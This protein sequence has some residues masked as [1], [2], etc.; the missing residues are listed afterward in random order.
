M[1][2]CEELDWSSELV[3]SDVNTLSEEDVLADTLADALGDTLGGV[4]FSVSCLILK[5]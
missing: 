4:A 3:L 2:N 5:T 1:T